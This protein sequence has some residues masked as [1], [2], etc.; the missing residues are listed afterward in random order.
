MRK[1]RRQLQATNQKL[2]EQ[3]QAIRDNSVVE[4]RDM[5]ATEL[6]EHSE[7][8]AKLA[9]NDVQIHRIDEETARE[10]SMPAIGAYDSSGRFNPAARRQIG[11]G[12][13]FSSMFGS[14]VPSDFSSFGEFL[15]VLDTG[16]A[17]N[18]LQAAVQGGS[19][20]VGVDGG[21]LIPPDFAATLMDAT[22]ESS[23][24][25]SRA[26][27]EPMQFA[28]KIVAGLDTQDHSSFIGGFIGV[29]IGEGGSLSGQKW[30][31][32][33]LV[34]QARKLGILAPVTSE[35]L[36][37]A[38]AFDSPMV[39]ALSNAMAWFLDY[40][41][42]NG[43]GVGQP[44]GVL[45]DPAL[46]V[47]NKETSQA[48]STINYENVKNMYS[49]LH[50]ACVNNAVWIINQG[51]RAQMLGLVQT[52]KN[53]AGTDNVGGS[54][55]P[56]MRDDGRGGFVLLGIPVVFTEKTP[57]LTNQGDII[58]ADL[59]QY[60]VG[61]RSEISIKK[62]EHLYFDSDQVAYRILMRA[63]GKGKWS[64]AMQ[65]KNGSTLSWAVTLQAR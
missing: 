29:W 11:G 17:D 25:A 9:A 49:R 41:F 59:S 45:N 39:T 33:Q 60:V 34:L 8:V 52:V 46:V 63:D 3:A 50:Q 61:M 28:Q 44:L 36:A 56:L 15:Q 35:L 53:V 57:A 54:A 58:L 10:L 21:F 62:S 31:L 2:K 38:P 64:Q 1:Q 43:N 55:D 23:V 65:P 30:K 4:G 20:G 26:Q 19:E 13:S 32:R 5:T 12:R 48:A 51:C 40:A 7:I 6:R 47:V 16:L 37:D 18:R 42:L 27:I 14:P 24:V 22:L